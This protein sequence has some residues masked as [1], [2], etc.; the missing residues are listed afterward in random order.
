MSET[1]RTCLYCGR[2]IGML[3]P[4]CD[5]RRRTCGECAE[6]RPDQ[7]WRKDG[8]LATMPSTVVCEN[9]DRFPRFSGSIRKTTAACE[10]FRERESDGK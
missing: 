3:G 7:Y 8:V 5:C 2:A 4:E 9:K 1:G 10:H 6:S